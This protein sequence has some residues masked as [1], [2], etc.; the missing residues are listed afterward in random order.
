MDDAITLFR[1]ACQPH[2]N[3]LKIEILTSLQR[4]ILCKSSMAIKIKKFLRKTICHVVA[5]DSDSPESARLTAFVNRCAG[6][7]PKF[8]SCTDYNIN[9]QSKIV[10]DI[11]LLLLFPLFPHF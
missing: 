8:F 9:L 2:S 7:T 11:K 10:R 1:E 5:K 6:S 4:K 3:S